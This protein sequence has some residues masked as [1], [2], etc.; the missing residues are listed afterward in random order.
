MAGGAG[1]LGHQ[2]F[3]IGLGGV[4]GGFRSA[5]LRRGNHA[6]KRRAERV[7]VAVGTGV[8]DV[9]RLA[10]AAGEDHVQRFGGQIAHGRIQREAVFF[11][12]CAEE[13]VRLGA[14]LAAG[15]AH[16]IE[17]IFAYRLCPVRND[18]IRVD[19]HLHAEAG[20]GGTGAERAVEGEG[21][22]GELLHGYAAVRTGQVLREEHFVFARADIGDHRAAGKRE[23]SFQRVRQA[24]LDVRAQDQAIDHDLDAVLFLLIQRRHVAHVVDFAVH[25]HA[26][27]S[28]LGDALEHLDML[29]LLGADH[30][31]EQLHARALGQGQ[32][33]IDHLIHTLL[34]D[35]AA[36]LGAMGHAHA[37]IKQAQIVV[38]FRHRAHG[39][40]GI[41]AGGLLVDGNRGG[42][43]VDGIAV[44]L[45][46]LAQELAR[47]GGEGLHIPALALGI[48]RVKG[49]RRFAAAGQAGED[50]EL[51][52]RQR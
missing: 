34:A 52:A 7:L 41:F 47:I 40:A 45:F 3:V 23:R 46:H 31:R 17:W 5:A 27:E 44:R 37:R 18:Q 32:H 49:E 26:Y 22:R 43:T 14:R 2:A 30:G 19:L 35:F 39:G 42:E 8:F 50:D 15:P 20:A 38:D 1:R 4:A 33:L 48:E 24:A 9:K 36:A 28:L 16:D 29:A 11:A 13:H 12:Q 21:A 25:A 51:V 10:L 6:L